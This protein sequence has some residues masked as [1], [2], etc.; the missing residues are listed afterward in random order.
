MRT[1]CGSKVL[2]SKCS[3]LEQILVWGRTR[4]EDDPSNPRWCGSKWP[5]IVGR[6]TS[7]NPKLRQPTQS[8]ANTN[9][10]TTFDKGSSGTKS[11]LEYRHDDNDFSGKKMIFMLSNS[12]GAILT[13]FDVNEMCF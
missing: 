1:E 5:R 12:C 4:A 9:I 2:V 10:F 7:R 13:S 3:F 11:F 8:S 6:E